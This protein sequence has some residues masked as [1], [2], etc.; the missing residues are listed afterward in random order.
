MPTP[1]AGS[2]VGVAGTAGAAVI[3]S[4]RRMGWRG[5]GGPPL[6]HT[7]AALTRWPVFGLI[8]VTT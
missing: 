2:G 3:G 8:E 6:I 5:W 7:M 1:G 4:G